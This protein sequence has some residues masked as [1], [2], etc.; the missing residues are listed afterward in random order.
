[1]KLMPHAWTTY[2]VIWFDYITGQTAC[3][4]PREHNTAKKLS[5]V[6]QLHY[7][8]YI[9]LKSDSLFVKSSI[10]VSI[11]AIGKLL[12]TLL[13]CCSGVTIGIIKC[14]PCMMLSCRILISNQSV[15]IHELFDIT[16]VLSSEVCHNVE[17][18]LQP[19]LYCSVMS[20]IVY[21]HKTA[22]SWL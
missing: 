14:L 17:P 10:S 5:F 16:A 11:I 20:A 3:W 13:V 12:K 2:V 19:Y 18:P 22:S 15:A 4:V 6:Q 1:M 8:H 9:K 21:A 7:Y